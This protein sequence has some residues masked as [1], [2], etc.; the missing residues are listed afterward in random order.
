MAIAKTEEIKA[1]CVECQEA[2]DDWRELGPEG[3]VEAYHRFQG[4]LQQI[5]DLTGRSYE[6]VFN[7]A[8]EQ[9]ITVHFC[10]MAES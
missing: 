8:I 6:E 5:A 3:R 7:E 2:E 1:L 4:L 9:W 10:E